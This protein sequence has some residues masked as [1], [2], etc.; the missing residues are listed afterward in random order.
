MA[1]NEFFTAYQYQAFNEFVD[2]ELSEMFQ[3][4]TPVDGNFDLD[5]PF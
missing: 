5:V 2:A 4:T 1:I 3:D